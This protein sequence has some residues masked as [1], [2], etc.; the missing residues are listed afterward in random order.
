M[1]LKHDGITFDI[2]T[3][4]TTFTFAGK[5]SARIREALKANR[6][7]WSP[8]GG[9][10]WRRSAGGAADLFWSIC[11]IHDKETGKPRR[12]DGP[13]TRCSTL[14]GYMRS[15]GAGSAVLCDD[16]NA[17]DTRRQSE[18]RHG[19]PE[20]PED[21]AGDAFDMMVEDDMARRCGD[22]EDPAGDA[23]DMMVEDDMAR[24]CGL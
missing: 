23:F 9:Y 13:C 15:L 7:R 16:C 24:R 22:P 8:S 4:Q 20:D 19:K 14:N 18:L 6:F 10:W 3:G 1:T 11:K 5:P 2:G 17:E 12:V 21:P